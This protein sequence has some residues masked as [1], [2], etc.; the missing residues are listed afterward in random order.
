MKL[1]D[2]ILNRLVHFLV[3]GTPKYLKESSYAFEIS[4]RNCRIETSAGL[5]SYM[6]FVQRG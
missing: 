6:V 1:I 4:K 2:E 3:E 5:T